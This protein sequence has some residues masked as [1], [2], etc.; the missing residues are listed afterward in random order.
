LFE[1]NNISRIGSL[2]AAGLAVAV[3]PESDAARLSADVAVVAL[4]DPA[5]VHTVYLSWSSDRRF[6]PAARG[7][8]EFVLASSGE[9]A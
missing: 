9:S 7:F 6:S 8:K 3:L 2:V 1:T 4:T 5:L